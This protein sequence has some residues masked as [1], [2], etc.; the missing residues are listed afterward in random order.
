[1]LSLHNGF[2]LKVFYLNERTLCPLVA[3]D[4]DANLWSCCKLHLGHF[5]C[6]QNTSI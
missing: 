6:A 5:N 4:S 1:M 2:E 3:K